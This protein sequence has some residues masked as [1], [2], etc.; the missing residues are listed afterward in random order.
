MINPL[1]DMLVANLHCKVLYT[2]CFNE[3]NPPWKKC[4]KFFVRLAQLHLQ[5]CLGAF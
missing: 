4:A 1:F 5:R 2:F 3:I